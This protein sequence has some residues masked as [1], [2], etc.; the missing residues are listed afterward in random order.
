MTSAPQTPASVLHPLL[1][2]PTA[3]QLF[4]GSTLPWNRLLALLEAARWAASSW[5]RQP[6]R[7]ILGRQGD[8]TF[9]TLRAALAARNRAA[10]RGAGALLLAATQARTAIGLP[11]PGT[12]Y[13][14]GLSVARLALQARATGWHTVQLGGFDRAALR[15]A[16]DIP[17]DFDPFVIVAVG[18]SVRDSSADATWPRLS[19][20]RR[21]LAEV[22]F[23]G[24]WGSAVPG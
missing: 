4:D 21:P 11:L 18:R 2:P 10:A 20:G 5:N 16:F 14:L 8:P 23:A 15:S 7:Y 13:E 19:R 9:N 22:A 6:W 17:P 1:A 24:R 3:G 12:E